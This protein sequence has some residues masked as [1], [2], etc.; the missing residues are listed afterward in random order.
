M[1]Q[2]AVQIIGR[3]MVPYTKSAQKEAADNLAKQ[4]VDGDLD[5]LETYTKIKAMYEALGIVLKDKAVVNAA[6]RECE[7]AGPSGAELQGA[8]II[9]AE[10]GVRYDFSACGDPI[11]DNLAA[12]KAA[13]D[14]QIKERETFLRGITTKQTLVDDETGEIAT[15]FPPAK[16]SSTCVKITFGK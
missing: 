7:L 16:T 12:Q 6:I 8:K 10:A 2:T 1:T 15:V 9:V 4:I 14:A 3:A 13:I 5:A 11:Y